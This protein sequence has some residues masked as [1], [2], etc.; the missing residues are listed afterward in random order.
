MN[1]F[2]QNDCANT[3][4]FRTGEPVGPN[5]IRAVLR[6]MGICIESLGQGKYNLTGTPEDWVSVG[7][8]L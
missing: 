3:I 1:F 8:D 7:F 6:K 5:T 2:L 4:I